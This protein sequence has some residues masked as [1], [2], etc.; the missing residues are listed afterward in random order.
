VRRRSSIYKTHRAPTSRR[1]PKASL[2]AALAGFATFGCVLLLQACSAQSAPVTQMRELP[3]TDCTLTLCDHANDATFTACFERIDTILHEFNMYSADSEI[4]AV[5][6]AAGNG[7][8]SVSED[9][10]K[11]L[12]QGL[13][14]AYLTD[15]LFDPTVGPLVKLWGVDSNNAHVPSREDIHAA[16]RLIGWREVVLEEKAGTVALRRPGMTLDFGAML[17]GFAAVETGASLPPEE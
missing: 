13:Q 8:V 16:L 6:R 12:R 9:F 4:S 15:G 14:L 11:A 7:A 10:R 1:A 5:N 2:L 17:K 3:F